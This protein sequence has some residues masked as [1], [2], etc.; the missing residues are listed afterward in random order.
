MKTYEVVDVQVKMQ[1]YPVTGCETSRLSYFLDNRLTD[2]CEVVSPTRRPPFSPGRFLVLIFV[3]GLVDPKAIVRL[4][5][6]VQFKNP[7]ILSGIGPAT[8]RLVA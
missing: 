1:S 6:L 7:M 2:G 3:R 5:G 4:E 8:F